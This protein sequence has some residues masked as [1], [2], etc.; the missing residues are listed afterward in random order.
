MGSGPG[1]YV[2]ETG[3][4]P[5][6]VVAVPTDLVAFVGKA[7]AGPLHRPMSVGSVVE[8]EREFGPVA[9]GPPLADAVADF[10]RNG[11]LRAVVVR[12][13]TV[14]DVAAGLDALEEFGLLVLA[15]DDPDG[16]VPPAAHD[17][18]LD[19]C[20]ERR[21]ML[22][23]DPPRA[24]TT[25]ADAVA[26]R[27]TLGLDGDRATNA[28]SYWPAV[29][30]ADVATGAVRSFP[31]SGA[32]AG[33]IA[34]TDRERGC[35][36]AP[37]GRAATLAVTGLAAAIDERD[38]Q[39]LAS[40]GINPLRAFPGVGTVAWGARTMRGATGGDERFRYVPVRRLALLIEASLERGLQW[41]V[42]EPNDEPLWTSVRDVAKTFLFT[43]F[44]QGAFRG[45]TPDE[46]FFVRCDR[47]TMT[48]ADIAAGRCNV[49]VAF[50]PLRP[51]EFVIVRLGLSTAAP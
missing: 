3:P 42:F 38:V 40:A 12:V 4:G 16:D 6:E 45:A 7:G 8:F 27:G 19:R 20:V 25:A 14:D 29:R 18:A 32:M 49:V 1:V 2:D 17:V 51:A 26:G 24:W 10:F 5:Q 11:G 50:A 31:P 43:L 22:L 41:A 21:A 9:G 15:A 13:P 28:A 39:V 30:R 34:R 23:V 48:D 35:W 47:S 33:V 44:R 36:H 46:A 37:S